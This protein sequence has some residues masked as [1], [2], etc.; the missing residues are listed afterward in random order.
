MEKKYDIFISYRRDG[1]ESTAR[2]LRDEL[3]EKGYRV[4]LDVESLSSGSF[5]TKLFSVIDEC[6]DFLVILSPGALNRCGEE[7]DWVRLEIEHALE[8]DKNIIPVFLRGFT[9]PEK[10]PESIERLRHLNGVETNFQ[11][12]HAFLE[13]LMGFLKTKSNAGRRTLHHLRNGKRLIL[14]CILA[15]MLVTV[16]GAVLWRQLNSYPRT[17][18][19]KNVTS[20]L[21]YYVEKN[22]TQMELAAEYL[23]TVYRA[24]SQYLVHFETA[25]RASLLTIFQTNRRLLYQIDLSDSLMTEELQAKLGNS[26]FRQADASAMHDY[27]KLFIDSAVDSIYF[28]E[29]LTDPDSYFDM[30][31]RENMLENYREILSEELKVMAYATNLLLLPVTKKDALKEFHHDYLPSLY[32][33]PLQSADWLWDAEDLE[34][35][36]E[37]SWNAIEKAMSR[38]TGQVGNENMELLQA[39]SEMVRQLVAEGVSPQEAERRVAEI[40]GKSQLLGEK[41]AELQDL[42]RQL[43][44]KKEE[45]RRKFAPAAE[46]EPEILWAKMLRFMSIRMYDDAVLCIDAYREKVRGTDEYAEEYCAAAVRL[47]RS[48]S[49]T[50]IDYGL[51]VAGYEP[52]CPRNEQYEIGDVI[53]SVNKIPC[54]NY[55]EYSSIKAELGE[56]EDYSVVVL[57]AAEDGSGYL[58]QK[59]LLIPARAARVMVLEMSENI[60]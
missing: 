51:L 28:M 3:T 16:L 44:E 23:D 18:R 41:Q 12:Y 8:K 39:R 49:A 19:E 50:G 13:K 26:P 37:K 4:F 22:M 53:I 57:R 21:I 31:T 29:F 14:A 46:D 45:A 30:K 48:I 36:S 5:D 25:D 7:E 35:R 27:L 40:E 34:S 52:D 56:N 24:C 10:M 59:E 9:F 38:I 58:E 32:Y 6:R 33:F 47:I 11:F 54:H 2:I 1:G 20:E 17:A 42:Q 55:E 60:V 15:L 43:E